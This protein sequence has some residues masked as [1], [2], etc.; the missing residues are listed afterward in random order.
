MKTN[1]LILS[2][3]VLT[4]A[5]SCKQSSEE[6]TIYT[7]ST[8]N[9]SVSVIDISDNQNSSELASREWELPQKLKEEWKN[10]KEIKYT[11]TLHFEQI[12]DI[13][14]VDYTVISKDSSNFI[15]KKVKVTAPNASQNY[16]FSSEISQQHNHG[17]KSAFD[18]FITVS[19][20]ATSKPRNNQGTEM[21]GKSYVIIAKNGVV[22]PL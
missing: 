14:L 5:I 17:N 3:L 12:K 2:V 13:L 16:S 19:I 11:D 9:K 15:F 6:K 18:M 1:T 20:F 8:Q 4:F 22:K 10:A 21:F 7:L